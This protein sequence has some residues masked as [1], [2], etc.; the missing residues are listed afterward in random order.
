[1]SLQVTPLQVAVSFL[2]HRVGVSCEK[3]VKEETL[4]APSYNP[5]D[6]SCTFQAMQ[7]LF[8]CVAKDP[9]R[10]R[11]CPCRDYQPQQVAFCKNCDWHFVNEN[12][13]LLCAS[14]C[15]N[16][17]SRR[18]DVI[19]IRWCQTRAK[20]LKKRIIF[21]K[22]YAI[23][24]FPIWIVLNKQLLFTIQG[25]CIDRNFQRGGGESHGQWIN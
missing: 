8:S 2:L 7:F 17:S 25:R 1:M 14:V 11:L 16:A 15:R 21:L 3:Q 13:V 5:A 9:A 19:D 24:F 22:S 20:K 4:H 12:P 23:I 18:E 6:Q 10:I